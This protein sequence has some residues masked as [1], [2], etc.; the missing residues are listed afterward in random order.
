MPWTRSPSGFVALPAS[1]PF[2]TATT[3]NSTVLTFPHALFD[4]LQVVLSCCCLTNED[5]LAGVTAMNKTMSALD[6]KPFNG[7]ERMLI[8]VTAHV[9]KVVLHLQMLC[10]GPLILSQGMVV[11]CLLARDVLDEPAPL[12]MVVLEPWSFM[13]CSELVLLR[14]QIQVLVTSQLT[15]NCGPVDGHIFLT[16]IQMV[17]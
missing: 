10:F 4:L 6:T 17:H 12:H 7:T 3:S 14:E 1:R 9:D 5:V 11:R 13:V 16:L 2:L 15:L 8:S